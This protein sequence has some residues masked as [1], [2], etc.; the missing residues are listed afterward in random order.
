[1]GKA[2]YRKYRSK[3]LSDIVGQSHITV[4]LE[5]AIKQGGISHA[6]L[7]TGPRGVGKTSVARIL[8]H[9]I[10]GFKYTEEDSHL[11]IIEIDAASN[12]G[13]DDI[14]SLRERA[15]VA[16]SIGKKKVYIIDEV[17]ML[18]NSAFNA[19]L[20]TLEEP[21][22][23]VI[24]IM[25]TTDAH[26]LPA[27]IISRSQQFVFRLISDED[28]KKHLEFISE[29]EGINI[30]NEA[31]KLIAKKASGSLRDA[32]S[33]LD[34]ISNLNNNEEKIN[35]KLIERAF[36]LAS[37]DIISEL[38]DCYLQGDYANI[39][40]HLNTL[41]N[42]GV[43]A[44]VIAEQLM[45]AVI[46]QKELSREL[47]ELTEKLTDVS[48]SN[49]P[50]IKLLVALSSRAKDKPETKAEKK[51]VVLAPVEKKNPEIKKDVSDN[52][53]KP[54]T[55]PKKDIDTSKFNWQDIL[56]RVKAKHTAFSS[57]LSKCGFQL[58]DGLTI[59]AGTAFYKKKL[60]SSLFHEIL[61]DVLKESNLSGLSVVISGGKPPIKDSAA[62]A[63]AD[64]M[65]G[66]EEVELSD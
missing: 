31:L 64:I 27:T 20:K 14:R 3:K 28:I 47:L 30:S 6:Y 62:A 39:V 38:I 18:S 58:T 33:L 42:D 12:N 44:D 5:N 4:I 43:K 48:K 63:I 19:L 11:D 36:G 50:N 16:P 49:Y 13:V 34:Q 21:P 51:K 54:A 55:S 8:A 7:F 32:L 35:R 52:K 1:M 56:S 46:A 23:H 60:D 41:E 53:A 37:E 29:K 25:A 65:G 2:L 24:F 9:N 57:I 10:N 45:K 15:Q 26:K 61:S 66:G 22:E 40:R 59:Y 17:H